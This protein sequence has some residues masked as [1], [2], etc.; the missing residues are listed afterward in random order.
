MKNLVILIF[1]VI[2]LNNAF[3]SEYQDCI[4]EVMSD[5]T[6]YEIDISEAKEIC[7][8]VKTPNR[9]PAVIATS[10]VF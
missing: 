10:E 4:K 6:V 1:A 3:S 9:Q 2:G 8:V 7:K 5:E